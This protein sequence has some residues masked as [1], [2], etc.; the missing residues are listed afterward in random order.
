[1]KKWVY[2]IIVSIMLFAV[3]APTFGFSSS[4]DNALNANAA[5]LA[6]LSDNS[7][8]DNLTNTMP[9]PFSLDNFKKECIASDDYSVTSATANV[10]ANSDFQSNFT[11]SRNNAQGVIEQGVAY[12]GVTKNLFKLDTSVAPN[13]SGH[14]R[15]TYS[16]LNYINTYANQ[17]PFA[18]GQWYGFKVRAKV[19]SGASDAKARVLI[20]TTVN[21]SSRMEYDQDADDPHFDGGANGSNWQQISGFVQIMDGT[22]R[23]HLLLSIES[24]SSGTVYFDDLRIYRLAL[25]PLRTVLITPSYKGLIF[26]DGGVGDI[27]MEAY[28]DDGGLFNNRTMYKI[29]DMRFTAEIVKFTPGIGYKTVLSTGT[30]NAAEKMEVTFSSNVLQNGDYYLRSSLTDKT[31]GDEICKD[32][33]TIRKRPFSERPNMYLDDY[34]RLVKKNSTTGKYDPYLIMQMYSGPY[35]GSNQSSTSYDVFADYMADSAIKSTVA[36]GGG[37]LSLPNWQKT[38]LNN[39]HSK[40]KQ[41]IVDVRLSTRTLAQSRDTLE[42]FAALFLPNS[43]I[44]AGSSGVKVNNTNVLGGYYLFDENNPIRYG[45][46]FIW[47]NEVL[48]AADINRPTYGCTDSVNE[49][50]DWVG[51]VDVLGVDVYPFRTSSQ[52]D[53]ARVGRYVKELKQKFPNRPIYY[54]LQ[55]FHYGNTPNY[56]EIRNMTWQA[57]CEGAEGIDW[58]SF[59]EITGKPGPD[60]TKEQWLN[61]AFALFNELAKYEDIIMS[62]DPAPTFTAS[63]IGTTNGGNNINI[64]TKRHDGKTYLFAVNNTYQTCDNIQIKVKNLIGN[65]AVK[66]TSVNNLTF[67][68]TVTSSTVAVLDSLTLQPLEVKIFEINQ[69]DYAS[70]KSEL[71]SFGFANNSYLV[72]YSGNKATLHLPNNIKSVQYGAQISKNATFSISNSSKQTISTSIGGGLEIVNGTL[73]LAGKPSSVTIEV[74]AQDR[75]NF[76]TKTYA[77]QYYDTPTTPLNVK[78]VVYCC[79][80]GLL[81]IA[82]ILLS[83]GVITKKKK[84]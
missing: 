40:N 44:P 39:L 52:P 68:E 11:F 83:C 49:Y 35:F 47:K 81:L 62:K 12:N 73:S 74:N 16:S 70:P 67:A 26:G 13:V 57:L 55:G 46:D 43:E 72:T 10:F 32:W 71:R 34:N 27:N 8:K 30:D 79:S 48:S 25:P 37:I 28:V 75:I 58:Y 53:I 65:E 54:I 3:V 80:A 4:S 64:M 82:I 63:G 36:Y 24:G 78:I 14:W 77:I 1:M 7:N 21:G 15:A 42:N 51:K 5:H 29:S 45:Q 22:T 56:G 23:L 6:N 60:K 61:E 20:Y 9:E 17:N 31:T 41:I 18:G 76:F 69:V 84:L 66:I 59:S 38:G 19:A 2:R 50:G 33:W